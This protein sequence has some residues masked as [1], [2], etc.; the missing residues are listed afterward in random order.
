MKAQK[1]AEVPSLGVEAAVDA[2]R[3]AVTAQAPGM[4]AEQRLAEVA[5]LFAD[6]L[7][8]VERAL[9]RASLEGPAPGTD[10]ARH[11]IDRGGKRLRPL[12][13]LLSAACFGRIPEHARELAVVAELV[14]SATL[15]HDDVIDDGKERRGAPASRT[16]WGNGVSVLGG[17]LLLV[18]ALERTARHAPEMMPELVAT[19]RRLVEGEII[20]LRGRVELDVSEATYERILRDKTASLFAWATRTGARLAAADTRSVDAMASFGE[21]LGVAFQLVDDVL[22][23]TGETSGKTLFAD[24]RQGKLTLPLVLAAAKDPAL[25][26]PLRRIFAGDQEPVALVSRA[27][28]ESG[29]CDEVR[30]RAREHTTRAIQALEAVATSPARSLLASVANELAAR[31]A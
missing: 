20:Q 3:S 8:W 6:D 7:L 29:A 31:A 15:L 21:E 1:V 23:Y 4:S 30:R 17:D 13:L 11:L 26:T 18:N 5:A 14:H 9:S 12:S 16:L 28:T 22:D 24:L 19:L 27:V 25:M 10:A 2:L